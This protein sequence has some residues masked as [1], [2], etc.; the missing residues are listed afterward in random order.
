[1]RVINPKEFG[2]HVREIRRQRGLTQTQ[3]AQK[4]GTT[5]TWLSEF[6][7]G[8][9]RAELG[10]VFRLLRSLDISMN[11]QAAFETQASAE[12]SQ[13]SIDIDSI[14]EDRGEPK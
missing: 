13:P 8:K 1:M 2:L 9:P 3:L 4:T 10:L 7:R 11:L 5:Q 6:E 14:V 12:S